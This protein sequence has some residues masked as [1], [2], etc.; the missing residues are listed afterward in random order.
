MFQSAVRTFAF[1]MPAGLVPDAG[2]LGA[3]N[4]ASRLRDAV[5]AI[6]P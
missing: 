2:R 4:L 3:N 1:D 5:G 6:T